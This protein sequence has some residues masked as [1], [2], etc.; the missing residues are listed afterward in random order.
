MKDVFE[1]PQ[2]LTN[3]EVQEV[4]CITNDWLKIPFSPNYG[5]FPGQLIAV[6]SRAN[7]DEN[8]P[9]GML[10]HSRMCQVLGNNINVVEVAYQELHLP[11]DIHADLRNLTKEGKPGYIFIIPLGDYN[12]RTIIFDQRSVTGNDFYRHKEVNAPVNHPVDLDFW[13]ENLS[14]CWDEDRLYLSL[15]Y[16]GREWRK[17]STMFFKRDLFHSSDNFHTQ[18]IGPKKFLQVLTDIV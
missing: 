7:W 4:L 6:Q 1:I 12:S 9:L 16:V 5:R 8:S 13:N 2:W 10:L 3:S 18:Q 17:G 11:W 15:K 14:H